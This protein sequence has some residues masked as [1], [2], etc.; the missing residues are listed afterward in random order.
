MD[1]A[2]PAQLLVNVVCS[3]YCCY[4]P[5]WFITLVVTCLNLYPVSSF[6]YTV[7]RLHFYYQVRSVFVGLVLRRCFTPQFVLHIPTGSSY[8]LRIVLVGDHCTCYPDLTIT[9]LVLQYSLLPALLPWFYVAQFFFTVCVL[10][11][12]SAAQHLDLRFCRGRCSYFHSRGLHCTP[13]AYHLLLFCLSRSVYATIWT[14]LRTPGWFTTPHAANTAAYVFF[15]LHLPALPARVLRLRFLLGLALHL[16][17]WVHTYP[18]TCLHR[19]FYTA[20]IMYS[21]HT[22]F[23][24]TTVISGSDV[25][26]QLPP[27]CSPV[28]FVL[29]M[30]YSSTCTSSSFTI[31][32]RCSHHLL[33]HTTQFGSG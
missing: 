21:F 15:F 1:Y 19:R 16:V 33:L 2:T 18:F 28:F 32:V 14:V 8:Y 30:V 24:T 31:T 5:H 6:F 20:C 12:S 23:H 4:R 29:V 13:V 17:V 27:P 11:A 22:A 3:C 25:P 26:A 9:L 7:T 10:D